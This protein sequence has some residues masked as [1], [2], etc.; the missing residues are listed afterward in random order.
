MIKIFEIKELDKI[1]DCEEWYRKVIDICAEH[2]M[3]CPIHCSG[4]C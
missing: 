3:D 4:G 2:E 1:K